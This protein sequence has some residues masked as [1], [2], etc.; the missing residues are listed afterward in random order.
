MS[1]AVPFV[2]KPWQ[3]FVVGSL[4]GW[5]NEAGFRRF[6]RGYVEIGKGNGKSPMAAGI[7]HYMLTA[8]KKLRA[9]VYSA[10][11]D[12]DQ[13]SILFR[14]AVEM[15]QRSPNLKKRLTPSGVEP[16]ASGHIELLQADFIGEE[17]QVRYPT[18]LRVD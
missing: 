15:W 17:R 12:K 1:R 7:G 16:D 18:V 8:Q 10:A 4:F 6:R 3:C 2:L 9:E 13:A 11:T 5:V 14:D